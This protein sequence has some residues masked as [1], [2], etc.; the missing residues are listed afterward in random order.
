MG[1]NGGGEAVAWLEEGR[2]VLESRA[3]LLERLKARYRDVEGSM[4]DELIQERREEAAREA[5]E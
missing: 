2:L 3:A 4:A 5:Q 1:V